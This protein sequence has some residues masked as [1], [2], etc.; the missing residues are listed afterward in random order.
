MQELV[1]NKGGGIRFVYK[2]DT[3]MAHAKGS[4]AVLIFRIQ[5]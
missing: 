4:G 1:V 5:R 2:M 3:Y